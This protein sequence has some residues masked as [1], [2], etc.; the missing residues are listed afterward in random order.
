MTKRGGGIQRRGAGYRQALQKFCLTAIRSSVSHPETL[1]PYAHGGCGEAEGQGGMEAAALRARGWHQA[2]WGG[3]GEEHSISWDNLALLG[4]APRSLEI[5]RGAG[6]TQTLKSTIRFSQPSSDIKGSR[7]LPPITER[8]S[9]CCLPAFPR[10]G[11]SAALPRAHLTARNLLT[12]QKCPNPSSCRWS[13][14]RFAGSSP[15][16]HVDFTS[17]CGSP[18]RSR[19]MRISPLMCCGACQSQENQTAT[20]KRGRLH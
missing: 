17:G 11:G 12:K 13:R 10:A 3:H 2:G 5:I 7:V 4:D 8:A 9:P 14:A 6:A 16:C 18:A 1:L 19:W 15:G 20:K